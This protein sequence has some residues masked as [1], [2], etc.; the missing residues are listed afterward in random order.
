MPWYGSRSYLN[1]YINENNCKKIMEIGVYNA[2][3]VSF[4]FKYHLAYLDQ[5]IH[6][7]VGDI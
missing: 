5:R 4:L 3:A 7:M 1:E 2:R 6:E